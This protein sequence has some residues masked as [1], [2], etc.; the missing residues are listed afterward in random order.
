[1]LE[2]LLASYLLQKSY[3][4][5]LLRK[6]MSLPKTGHLSHFYRK[7]YL[8]LN[9]LSSDLVILKVYLFII[10]FQI[11]REYLFIKLVKV[12]QLGC[13]GSGNKLQKQKTGPWSL[14]EKKA[15]VTL[16]DRRRKEEEGDRKGLCV[17]PRAC[18]SWF[19]VFCL[20]LIIKI[21]SKM[22]FNLLSS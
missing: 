11:I 15:K 13:I 12:S 18:F 22:I 2:P 4:D 16:L 20:L 9:R 21:K 1:M 6:W 3:K 5:L 10:L 19:E 14:E 17:L 8:L 7:C